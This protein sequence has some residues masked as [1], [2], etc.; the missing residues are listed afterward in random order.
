[1]VSV[2]QVNKLHFTNNDFLLA[3]AL[4][5]GMALG[6]KE[7]PKPVARRQCEPGPCWFL[8]FLPASPLNRQDNVLCCSPPH[9]FAYTLPTILRSELLALM[10]LSPCQQLR[11]QFKIFIRKGPRGSCQNGNEADFGGRV[12]A[13]DPSCTSFPHLS[14]KFSLLLIIYLKYF[15]F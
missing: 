4:S 15:K 13:A 3:P 1:M 5:R 11:I 7:F 8:A 6:M 9:N 2:Q 14:E 10:L 12:E